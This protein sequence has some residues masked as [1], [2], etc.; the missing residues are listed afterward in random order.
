[1][2]AVFGPFRF[3]YKLYYGIIVFVLMVVLMPFMLI[4]MLYKPWIIR[5]I[6]RIRIVWSY[7]I[8]ALTFLWMSRKMEG[9]F[10]DGPFIICA[11]HA[12]YIDIVLMYTVV[13][14]T[15]RFLGKVELVKWPVFG[16]FF[17]YVDIPVDRA[18]RMVARN[19]IALAGASLDEGYNVAIFPEGTI[20]LDTPNLM[21]FKNGAF[22]LAI[23]KQV[24]I[25]PVT[26]IN[27]HIRFSEPTE[28]FGPA[29]PGPSKVIVH[30][31]IDTSGMTSEDLIPLR[32]R[33]YALINETLNGHE[34]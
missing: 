28:W 11:N 26:F 23:T 3:L 18:T 1:M 13:P 14:K 6:F 21:R 22:N 24:P 27:N 17:K 12:S 34:S 25:V 29:S 31:A 19:A 33:V 7:M 4:C 8:Q 30:E 10:P 15:F 2:N 5:G 20:P 32:E 16:Y 9:K